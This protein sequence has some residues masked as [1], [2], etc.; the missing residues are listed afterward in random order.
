[1]ILMDTNT[2]RPYSYLFVALVQIR[3]LVSIIRRWSRPLEHLNFLPAPPPI[4]PVFLYRH[5]PR[6][7]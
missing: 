2:A 4:F 7:R 5:L 6:E 1:M 3:I